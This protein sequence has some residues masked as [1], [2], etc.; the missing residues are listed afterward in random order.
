MAIIPKFLEKL[1]GLIGGIPKFLEKLGGLIGGMI[2]K[3]FGDSKPSEKGVNRNWRLVLVSTRWETH[4]RRGREYKKHAPRAKAGIAVRLGTWWRPE[5]YP[6][7]YLRTRENSR[8]VFQLKSN[9]D[10][11]GHLVHSGQ[12]IGE[13]YVPN[14]LVYERLAA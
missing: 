1:G 4:S 8:R 9:A 14:Q 11:N 3:A 13:G 12:R 10:T 2:Q 7:G 6:N 5:K